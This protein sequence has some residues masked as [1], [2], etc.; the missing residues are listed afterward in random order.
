MLILIYL[1]YFFFYMYV[2]N[3]YETSLFLYHKAT[4]SSLC[5]YQFVYEGLALKRL[6]GWGYWATIA[7]KDLAISLM[8]S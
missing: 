8:L 2:T 6:I 5:L 7:I 4:G 3:P 1:M